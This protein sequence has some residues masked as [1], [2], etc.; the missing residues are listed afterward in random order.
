[1]R[2]TLLT[3]WILATI[4]FAYSA[5]QQTISPAV[6]IEYTT[7]INVETGARWPDQTV[8]VNGNRIAAF[9]AA[10][11]VQTPTGARVVDGRGKFLIPGIWDMHVHALFNG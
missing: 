5:P 8:V 6:V 2:S 9:G 7:I 1:M 4:L 11:S 3:V 10:G